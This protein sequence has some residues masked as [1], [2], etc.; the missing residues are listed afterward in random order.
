MASYTSPEPMRHPNEPERAL[1]A[2]VLG[3]GIGV[4]LVGLA[5]TRRTAGRPR[6]GCVR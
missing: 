2:I 4:A 6:R 5:R 1:R 3:L